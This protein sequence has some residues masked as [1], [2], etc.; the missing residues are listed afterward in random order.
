MTGKVSDF[1]LIE[2]FM[3]WKVKKLTG[4]TSAILPNEIQVALEFRIGGEKLDDTSFTE[5]SENQ[6][7]LSPKERQEYSSLKRIAEISETFKY[8]GGGRK[9]ANNE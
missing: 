5:W 7:C 2:E 1:E 8:L 9:G 4:K 6:A 3:V